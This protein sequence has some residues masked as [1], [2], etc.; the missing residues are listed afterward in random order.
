MTPTLS[1]LRCFLWGSYPQSRY[2]VASLCR[3]RLEVWEV[4]HLQGQKGS[5]DLLYEGCGSEW[6]AEMYY[7]CTRGCNHID[8]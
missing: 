2:G 4:E 1:Y 3:Q 6:E 5:Q 7:G 8:T